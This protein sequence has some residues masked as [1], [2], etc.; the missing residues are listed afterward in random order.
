MRVGEGSLVESDLIK[1]EAPFEVGD[2]SSAYIQIEFTELIEMNRLIIDCFRR[3]ANYD[4]Y[5]PA[6]LR[7][8][9]IVLHLE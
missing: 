6:S 8:T 3:E 7:S 4:V 1:E 9:V 2:A 5:L